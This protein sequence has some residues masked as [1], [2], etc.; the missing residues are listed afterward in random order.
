MDKYFNAFEKVT[1]DF[2]TRVWLGNTYAGEEVFKGRLVDSQDLNIPMSYLT[3]RADVEPDPRPPGS[4]SAL[5]PHRHE[6]RSK[7]PK[8]RTGGLRVHGAAFVRAVDDKEDVKQNAEGGWTISPAPV[9]ASYGDDGCFI[10][11]ISRCFG[12]QLPRPRDIKS[13]TGNDRG[14]SRRHTAG[15]TSVSNTAADRSGHGYWYWRQLLVRTQ[16]FRDE[17]AEALLATVGGRVQLYVRRSLRTT[18][19]PVRIVPPGQKPRKCTT[20][21]LFWAARVLIL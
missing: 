19:G 11:A 6:V 13:R 4:R 18:P 8:A 12:G 15:I 3:E 14:N 2:V 17:R 20:P 10:E 7:E 1:P 9:P 5:L 16:N 21:R